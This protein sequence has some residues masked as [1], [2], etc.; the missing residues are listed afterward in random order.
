MMSKGC[1]IF[2]LLNKQNHKTM[3][4]KGDYIFYRTK[5]YGLFPTVI[6]RVGPR[7][8]R[9]GGPTGKAVWV[10]PRNCQLQEEWRKEMGQ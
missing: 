3:F 10:D 9:C 1:R 4:K 5:E 6:D 2:E 7:R 8:V